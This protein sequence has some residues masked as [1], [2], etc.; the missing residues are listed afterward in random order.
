MLSSED[1]TATA[2]AICKGDQDEI[3]ESMQTREKIHQ[4]DVSIQNKCQKFIMTSRFN[5]NTWNENCSYRSQY[6]K[7][8]CIY[9]SPCPVS[10][11]V[12]LD[13][14]MFVLEMNNDENRIMGIGTVK[15]HPRVNGLHVYEHANYN[16]YQFYGRHRID[17]ADMV[18]DEEA[19]MCAF[20]ILCFTGNS[21]QKRGQGLKLFPM[22]ML[23]RCMR[24][25]DLVEFISNMFKRRVAM[26]VAS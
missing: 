17:R 4:L 24:V 19:V 18:G 26:A 16:R 25:I 1:A 3:S 5:T 22:E 7:F 23:F 2:T 6:P 8:G 9:C 13:S 12:P 21:H 15:N 10:S 20:D 11:R 14:V